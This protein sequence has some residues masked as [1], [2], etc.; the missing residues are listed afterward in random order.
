LSYCETKLQYNFYA[1][2]REGS[3]FS[4]FLGGERRARAAPGKNWGLSIDC[5]SR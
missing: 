1:A 3:R 5:C 4:D 2:L